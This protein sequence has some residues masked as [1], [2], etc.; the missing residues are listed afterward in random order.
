VYDGQNFLLSRNTQFWNKIESNY[1]RSAGI[2]LRYQQKLLFF[3]Y[4]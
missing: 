1:I 4:L 3:G 2:I